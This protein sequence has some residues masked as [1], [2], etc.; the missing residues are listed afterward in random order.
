MVSLGREGAVWPHR[1]GGPSGPI[2]MD[3]MNDAIPD[4]EAR[5][6][7]VVSRWGHDP[8]SLVQVLREVQ[9]DCGLLP[10]QAFGLIAR[11]LRIP[12]S[13]VR[14]VASFYSFLAVEPQGEYRVLFSDN[15]TDRMAG[16]ERLMQAMCHRLWV[17]PGKVSEDG[18]VSVGRTSCTGPV[19]PGSRA[20]GER[21]RGARPRRGAHRSTV[22]ADPGAYAAH[23]M[24]RRALRRAGQRAP[25]GHPA[26]P[27]ARA[28]RCHPGGAAARLPRLVGARGER[29][30][31]ARGVRGRGAG[32]DRHARGDQ[33][34]EPA[35]PRRRGLHHRHQVGSLPP[36]HGPRALRGLQRGR[37]RARHLQ[38]P[39]AAHRVTPTSCSTA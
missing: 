20:A 13:R 12:Y 18:L 25:R 15:I 23:G 2:R 3:A 11:Y 28:R 6:R 27:R 10:P 5:V 22:R 17:E 33:A 32:T 8:T 35:R 26:R 19:R 7:R 37:G 21:P 30:L 39:R 14:G 24:A 38:G 31:L 1:A 29:A 34:L 4:L 16:S 9:E 36:R